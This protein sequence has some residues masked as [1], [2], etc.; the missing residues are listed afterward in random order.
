MITTV[1]DLREPFLPTLE[2]V[3]RKPRNNKALL[4]GS[5]PSID[6]LNIKKLEGQRQYDICTLTDAISIFTASKSVQ[7]AV[8]FHYQGLRRNVDKLHLAQ[9][10][11]LPHAIFSFHIEKKEKRNDSPLDI[12]II[13]SLYEKIK[14]LKNIYFFKSNNIDDNDIRK[15][16]FNT[17]YKDNIIVQ[18]QG[19][20]VG[21]FYFLTAY[22]GYKE[23]YYV[24]FD[25]SYIES[26]EESAQY[27]K[28][29]EHKKKV[30]KL[31]FSRKD[32]LNSW[33]NLH[34]MKDKYYNDVVFKLFNDEEFLLDENIASL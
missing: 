6:T 4:I 29:I 27:A 18:A 11:L 19:S 3:P 21:A 22:M 28:S 14:N 12:E 26:A 23:I 10:V 30:G 2:K 24:G 7:Y 20:V 34:L 9:Y 13:M 17:E 32:Y 5:G 25:G 8:N 1:D 33:K 16:S 31:S 15:G